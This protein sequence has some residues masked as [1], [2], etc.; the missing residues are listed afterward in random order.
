VAVD[1]LDLIAVCLFVTSPGEFRR[2]NEPV[3]EAVAFQ[4]VGVVET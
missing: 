2:N 4:C 1:A 3:V